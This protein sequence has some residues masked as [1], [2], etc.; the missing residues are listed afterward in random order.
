MSHNLDLAV[1]GVCS[2]TTRAQATNQLS[3]PFLKL[4]LGNPNTSLNPNKHQLQEKNER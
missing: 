4:V 2:P 1:V 3:K